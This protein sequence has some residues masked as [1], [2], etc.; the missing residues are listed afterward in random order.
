MEFY[1]VI[2]IVLGVILLLC[3]IKYLCNGPA[4]PI[5]RDMTGKVILITGA[6]AGIG[7]ETAIELLD[8]GATVICASRSKDRSISVINK[9]RKPE[10]GVFYP[11]DLSCY[12][13]TVEFAERIKKDFPNGIDILINNAGQA[14]SN[15]ELTNDGIEKSIQTNHLGHFVLTAL[16]I[17]KFIKPNGK[18]INVSSRGHKRTKLSLVDSLEKD[19]EFANVRDYYQIFDFYCFTKMANVIHAKFLAKNFPYITSASLHPGVVYSDIW[20]KTEGVYNFIINC[21]KPFA[22]I[23]MKNEKMGAQTTVYLAY[24]DNHKITNGG[25]YK[26]CAEIAPE[27]IVHYQG[28]D[29]RIMKYTKNLLDK[30]FTNFPHDLQKHLEIIEKMTY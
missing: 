18:I 17:E 20:D 7:K 30:Y 3:L 28:M 12:K 19:L 1:Y 10:N 24:E 27:G 22:Y 15:P 14:F 26:D 16:L 6:S 8:Q 11:L 21:L 25:Y 2:A 13:S 4:S 9:S 5:K 23:F 29:K